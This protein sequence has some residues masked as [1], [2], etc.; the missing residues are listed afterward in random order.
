MTAKSGPFPTIPRHAQRLFPAVPQHQAVSVP[1]FPPLLK[2]ERGTLAVL[3]TSRG[4]RR[5]VVAALGVCRERLRPAPDLHAY[6]AGRPVHDV[7]LLIPRRQHA[8]LNRVRRLA[9]VVVVAAVAVRDHHE[10]HGPQANAAAASRARPPLG[11]R[12]GDLRGGRGLPPCGDPRAVA[13]PLIKRRAGSAMASPLRPHQPAFQREHKHWRVRGGPSVPFDGCPPGGTESDGP[14]VAWKTP[15]LPSFSPG[16]KVV[17]GQ[18][19]GTSG[20][21]R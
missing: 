8:A 4:A 7:P 15:P 10:V 11:V 17:P 21:P 12:E 1:Q 19:P 6:P 13:A 18:L 2:G 3:V 14:L 9:T 20:R 5:V 16:S